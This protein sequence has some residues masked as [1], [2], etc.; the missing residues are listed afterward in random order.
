MSQSY[1]LTLLA[2]RGHSGKML[3]VSQKESPFFTLTLALVFRVQTLESVILSMHRNLLEH[4]SVLRQ[5]SLL[6]T[7][8]MQLTSQICCSHPDGP[9]PG[10]SVYS[11][12]SWDHCDWVNDSPKLPCLLPKCVQNRTTIDSSGS[13]IIFGSNCYY[14]LC[15]SCCKITFSTRTA[16]H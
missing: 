15:L 11:L 7:I 2:V 6:G 5:N 12:S 13:Q 10:C 3:S 1:C 14:T 9:P 8:C 4:S 16:R